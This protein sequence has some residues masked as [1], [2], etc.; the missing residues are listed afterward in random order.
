MVK[1]YPAGS[2]LMD[3]P[4]HDSMEQVVEWAQ[5]VDRWTAWTLAILDPDFQ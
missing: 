3:V 5:D 1:P 4:D 2:I